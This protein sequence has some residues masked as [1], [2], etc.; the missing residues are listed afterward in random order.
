M[1]KNKMTPCGLGPV[2]EPSPI[3]S[4]FQVGDFMSPIPALS[5]QL[6]LT[7]RMRRVYSCPVADP[8]TALASFHL[9]SLPESASSFSLR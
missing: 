1:S 5:A 2:S 8:P 7:P 6:L 3:P 4:P 9:L